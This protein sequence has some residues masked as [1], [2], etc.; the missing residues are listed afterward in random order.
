MILKVIRKLM[1]LMLSLAQVIKVELL[2]LFLGQ[3][4]VSNYIRKVNQPMF[5]L[6]YL[7][8]KI[9][10]GTNIWP[11]LTINCEKR[12]KYKLLKIG[13]EVRI[14]WDVIIDLND[15]IIIEDYVHVGANNSLITHYSLGNTPLG[16]SEYPTEYGNIKIKTGVALAWDCTILYN[17]IIGE[18]T[19]ISPRSVIKGEVPSFCVFGGNPSRPIKKI[20]RKIWMILS[21]RFDGFENGNISS[22]F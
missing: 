20:N 11:G 12:S 6:K 19:V 4:A 7:G 3:R 18:H 10:K 13:K 9:G 15:E 22:D 21:R 8:V 16:K 14:L 17:S 5:L 2:Y 1:Q